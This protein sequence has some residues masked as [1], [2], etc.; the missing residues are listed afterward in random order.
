MFADKNKIARVFP[1]KTNVTPIDEHVYFDVPG[2]FTPQYDEVHISTV[3]SWDIERAKWLA[4]QWKRHGKVILGVPAVNDPGGD[5]EL[6][7]YLKPGYVI[8]SSDNIA[9]LAYQLADAMLKEREK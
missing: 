6:G 5:F 3:F 9:Q 1:S 2:L 7:K 4:N 8:T